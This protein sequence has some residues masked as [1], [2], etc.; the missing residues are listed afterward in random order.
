MSG[1][2]EEFP[3][4]TGPAR[5]TGVSAGSDR[6]PPD[7]LVNRLYVTDPLNSRI[8]YFCFD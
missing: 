5:A 1:E 2:I 3:I 7:R 4:A 8:V 6:Q